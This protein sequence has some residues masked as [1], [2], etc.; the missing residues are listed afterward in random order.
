[1]NLA[2]VVVDNGSGY[3]KSGF[4]GDE[5]PRYRTPTITGKPKDAN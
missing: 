1:M 3:I 5:I 2:P 4:A